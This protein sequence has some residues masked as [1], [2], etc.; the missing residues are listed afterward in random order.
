MKH[1]PARPAAGAAALAVALVLGGVAQAAGDAPAARD[2]QVA[3]LRAQVARMREALQ[4]MDEELVR[5]QQGAASPAPVAPVAAGGP[6]A[7]ALAPGAAAPATAAPAQSAPP[8]T[9]ADPGPLT[10]HERTVLQEQAHSADMIA[11]WRQVHNGMTQEQV[12]A[13]LGA[14]QSQIPAGNRTGWYYSYGA[15]GGASVFFD[16]D[17]HVISIMAPRAGAFRLY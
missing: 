16:H 11:A 4:Q 17:G 3:S 8:A 12:R 13:L 5:L 15:D 14:P 7:P 10:A 1:L 2:A 9:A 6:P